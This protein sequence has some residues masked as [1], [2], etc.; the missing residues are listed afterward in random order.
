MI[1]RLFVALILGPPA[2]WLAALMSVLVP[3]QVF[4]CGINRGFPRRCVVF[5][6]NLSGIFQSIG[7]ISTLGWLFAFPLSII[8]LLVYS[9]PELICFG[10]RKAR[11]AEQ[12]SLAARPHQTAPPPVGMLI[13]S[14]MATEAPETIWI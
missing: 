6:A 4:G 8:A 1:N 11:G 13:I 12:L 2:I 7:V 10:L 3:D 5:G 9:V 14:P